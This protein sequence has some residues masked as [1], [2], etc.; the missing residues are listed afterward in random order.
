MMHLRIVSPNFPSVGAAADHTV[1]QQTPTRSTDSTDRHDNLNAGGLAQTAGSVDSCSC[2]PRT[3]VPV[4]PVALLF[5]CTPANTAKMEEW[6][7]HR[8]A[9]LS[10]N[11][12]LHRPLPCMTGSPVEIHLEDGVIRRAVHTTTPV[13]IHRQEQV[14]SDLKRDEAP[15]SSKV[16]STVSQCIGATA[17]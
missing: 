3:V 10:F 5:E 4:H 12:C 8:F 7:I 17:W 11:T 9:S 15:G 16:S 1:T 6:V 14:L 13:P 2:P